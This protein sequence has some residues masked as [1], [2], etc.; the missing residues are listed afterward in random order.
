MCEKAHM[1]DR[2]RR[3]I[4]LFN[5]AV[6]NGSLLYFESKT[7]SFQDN[8]HKFTLKLC[9]SIAKKESCDYSE[10]KRNPFLP[11]DKNLLI[12]ELPSTDHVLIFNK[13]SLVKP[14][15]LLITREFAPQDHTLSEADFMAVRMFYEQHGTE[16]AMFYNCG[17]LSGASQPHRHFQFI[18]ISECTEPFLGVKVPCDTESLF[19]TFKEYKVKAN[20]QGISFNLIY[21]PEWGM[22]II[23]RKV[24]CCALGFSVNSMGFMGS[25]LVKTE[26]D[27]QRVIEYGPYKL[28]QD[29]YH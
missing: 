22:Y 2:K 14:H 23:P 24:E 18:P 10:T 29:L 6:S 21:S 26:H 9:P 12:D 25:I 19:E 5:A 20:I 15:V 17:P 13:F 11:F 4:K 8:G 7:L 28:L 3:I 27:L 1:N 16:Y